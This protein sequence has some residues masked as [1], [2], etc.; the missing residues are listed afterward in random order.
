MNWVE[1][2]QFSDRLQEAGRTV[3]YP[4][5]GAGRMLRAIATVWRSIRLHE[6]VEAWCTAAHRL[7]EQYFPHVLNSS[8]RPLLTLVRAWARDPRGRLVN[9]CLLLHVLGRLTLREEIHALL[10]DLAA[11]LPAGGLVIIRENIL[12]AD[13]EGLATHTDIGLMWSAHRCMV[14]SLQQY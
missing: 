14:R 2:Q 12:L 8:I 10:R 9:D 13:D 6:P 4:H 5:C 3:F 1:G 11:I 7:A